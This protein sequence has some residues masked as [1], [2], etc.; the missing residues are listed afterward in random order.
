MSI[1]DDVARVHQVTEKLA[2]PQKFWVLHEDCPH[3]GLRIELFISA[4]AAREFWKQRV[5]A[6][7]TDLHAKETR[8]ACSLIDTGSTSLEYPYETYWSLTECEV[9]S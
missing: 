6:T 4:R 9:H 3:D 8:A 5:L 1:E 2:G 7:V